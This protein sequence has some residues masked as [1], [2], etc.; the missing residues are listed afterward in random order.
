MKTKLKLSLGT[1]TAALGLLAASLINVGQAQTF[2]NIVISQFNGDEPFLTLPRW[3]G[4]TGYSA[5]LDTTVNNPTDLATNQPGSGSLKATADWTGTSGNGNGAPEPQLMLY[6]SFNGSTFNSSVTAS[7]Y[8]YDLD[9]DLMI[10]PASAKTANGDFGRIRAGVVVG[11]S[12]S[13][14]QLWEDP[15]YTNT[16]WTHIHAYIDPAIPGIDSMNGF[17][18]YWPW[19]T[20]SANAGAVQ[21]VQTFWLDNIILKTNLTKP[22]NPPTATLTPAPAAPKGLTI[23]S[24]GANQYDRNAIATVNGESWIDAAGPVTYSL[25]ISKYPDTN[26][27]SYQTHIMLVPNPGTETAP[28]WNEPNCVFLDIQNQA[29]GN[30]VA[31][32]RYKTNQAGGNSVLYGSGALGSVTSTNGAVGTWSMTFLNNTDVVLTSADGSTNT[33]SFPDE[34][35]VKDNFPDSIIAYFGAQP[36]STKDIGQGIVLSNVKITGTA[37]PINDSFTGPAL[38]TST[39]VLRASQP[40]DVYIPVSDAAFILSWTL[41]DANFSLQVGPS[42]SGPWTDPGL[43]NTAISGPIKSVTVPWSALP[44]TT[45]SFFRFVKPVA[46]KLQ[47]L[48]PGETAAPGT[49]TGKTGTPDPQTAGANVAVTVNAVDDKWNLVKYV[50]DNVTITSSDS[51]ASLPADAALVGGTQTFTVIFGTQGSQTVTATDVTD[52]KK[53]SGTSAS[54]TVQ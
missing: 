32:F 24:T 35:A 17:Y 4:L 29:N 53:A 48:L 9:F 38:D 15:A 5:E 16:G 18:L 2:T 22:L 46:T 6:N 43:T 3:W 39:W 30:A 47:V 25:T 33:V 42:L 23:T 19:Q 50:T 21:G 51:N 40:A 12:W 44:S 13:Q 28:D 45:S 14:V 27:P 41:P 26:Y 10:D 31:N 1:R 52:S 8:Y 11:P 36:N 20:D 49:A 34:Q 7:G 37:N 54:T